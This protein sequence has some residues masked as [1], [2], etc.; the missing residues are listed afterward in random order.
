V[1]AFAGCGKTGIEDETPQSQ[2]NEITPDEFYDKYCYGYKVA[3]TANLCVLGKNVFDEKIYLSGIRNKKLWIGKFDAN[4]KEQIFEFIDSEDLK[5]KK[6]I[7]FGEYADFHIDQSDVI[8]YIEGEDF[9]IVKVNLFDS[10][11]NPDYNPISS[12]FRWKTTLLIFDSKKSGKRYEYIADENMNLL[13]WYHDSYL[14]YIDITQEGNESIRLIT[15]FNQYGDTI[16]TGRS[17]FFSKDV[18]PVDFMHF[19]SY[20]IEWRPSEG[21]YYLELGLDSIASPTPSYSRWNT[22]LC[23]VED[24]DSKITSAYIVDKQGDMWR[25]MFEILNRS[26]S[27]QLRE[28]TIN[29]QTGEIQ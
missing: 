21:N 12:I 17:N 26:G 23:S 3:D 7:G 22:R 10:S 8:R 19:I 27:S 4:T 5:D 18:F 14:E 13:E 11:K 20:K 28:A 6:H 24:Y 1:I 15:C 16:L 9:R 2:E 25:F 29:I